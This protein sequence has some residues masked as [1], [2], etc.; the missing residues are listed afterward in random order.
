MNIKLNIKNLHFGILLLI[1]LIESCSSK[2]KKCGNKS[3]N[4]L[5]IN[6]DTL[7][8]SK[9]FGKPGNL[10]ID[11]VN[12]AYDNAYPFNTWVEWRTKWK[13]E[14]IELLVHSD[15]FMVSP[16]SNVHI[17]NFND[18]IFYVK[19][20]STY[21]GRKYINNRNQLSIDPSI[22]P[23]KGYVFEAYWLSEP[24]SYPQSTIILEYSRNIT[25]EKN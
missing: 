20:D 11:W 9:G 16:D 17:R 4:Q 3:D 14:Y 6:N 13:E 8:V 22:R 10:S 25:W 24:V 18:T 15:V 1:L 12:D 19:V 7:T 23:H 21:Q 2:I 5:I